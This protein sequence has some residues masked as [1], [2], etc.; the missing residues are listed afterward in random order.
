MM[1]RPSAPLPQQPFAALL[2]QVAERTPGPGGGAVAALTVALAASL[3][4]MTARYDDSIMAQARLARANALRDRML[5]IAEIERDVYQAVLE[6]EAMDDEHPQ[7]E[8]RL[9]AALAAASSPAL[10]TAGAGAKIAALAAESATQGNP[11]LIGDA[12]T[13][14]ELADGAT[15]AAAHLVRMNLA[16]SPGDPR[17]TEVTGLVNAAAEALEE[18]FAAAAEPEGSAPAA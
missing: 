3:V 14:A 8:N 7:R 17:R 4:E 5:E 13:A 9:A 6:A 12:V 2:D 1:S 16:D 18:A 11:A 15:R 10:T